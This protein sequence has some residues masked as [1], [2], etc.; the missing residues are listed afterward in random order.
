MFISESDINS[1]LNSK[2][3]MKCLNVGSYSYRQTNNQSMKE[4]HET[5]SWEQSIAGTCIG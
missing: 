1:F 5:A 3:S 4:N 2:E